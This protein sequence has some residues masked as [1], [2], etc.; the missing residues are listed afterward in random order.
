[1]GA[2]TSWRDTRSWRVDLRIFKQI[3][4]LV[5]ALA[6]LAG[7]ATSGDSAPDSALP[8]LNAAALQICK[9]LQTTD[10]AF[11]STADGDSEIYLYESRTASI[12]RLT[13]TDAQDHWASWSQDGQMIAY[14]SLRDG[15]REIYIQ[16]LPDGSPVNSSQNEEQDLAPSW[17]PNNQY[18]V[19]YSSR[20]LAWSG[21]GPIGGH[22]YVMRV[23]GSVVGR[24][25]TE[26]FFSPSMIAW[27]PDSSTLFYARYGAGKEGI[28]SLDLKTG[29][30]TALLALEDK[31]P[32]IASTNPAAGTVDFYVD[33]DDGVAIYQ[34]S[35][36]DGA[37]RRLTPGGGR[38]YYASWSPD[39]SALLVTAAEDTDGQAFDIRCIAADGAYDVAVIND[40]SDARSA[41]WRPGI[42]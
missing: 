3:Q 11:T 9:P 6:A 28:Y 21:T 22:L 1:M 23:Q 12:R 10:F 36:D 5:L 37:S 40:A 41:A 4:W 33:V 15:N 13:D 14:Q 31:F 18:I 24:I 19:Y 42:Y 2:D 32:G 8:G 38:Y 35:L 25:Q 17:S 20:D 30:E 7:C 26:P 39:R 34:L 29:E 16:R 27:S